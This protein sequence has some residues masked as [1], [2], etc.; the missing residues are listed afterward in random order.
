LV[1]TTPASTATT[2]TATTTAAG[3]YTITTDR[4]YVNPAATLA[5]WVPTFPAGTDDKVI[6]IF[7]GGTMTTG[8]VVTAITWPATLLGAGIYPTQFEAGE[9]ATFRFSSVANLWRAE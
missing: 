6:R 9:S 1:T 8:V 2:T 5:T 3:A 7:F 4:V